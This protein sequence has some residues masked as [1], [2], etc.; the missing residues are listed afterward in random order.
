MLP[1][2]RTLHNKG[3]NRPKISYIENREGIAN[4]YEDM[5]Y[6]KDC[7]FITSYERIEEFLPNTAHKWLKGLEK[8]HYPLK[9]R[10]LIAPTARDLEFGRKLKQFD[11]KVKVLESLKNMRMDFALADNKLAITSFEKEPFLVVIESQT[12]VDS[13]K[14]IFEIAWASGKEIK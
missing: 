5:N 3:Q 9:S 4:A 2:M 7:F 14:P 10:N 11:Q 8:G 6:A 12:L 13:I 1:V